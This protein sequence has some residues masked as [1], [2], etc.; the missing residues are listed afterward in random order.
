M[1][2]MDRIIQRMIVTSER[3][4]RR[5]ALLSELA[6]TRAAVHKASLRLSATETALG[7]CGSE[8]Q[9]EAMRSAIRRAEVE[10]QR[11]RMVVL[12]IMEVL[13]RLEARIERTQSRANIEVAGK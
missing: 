1:A 6:D 8:A 7:V 10:A 5:V 3:L 13:A 12:A 2:T 4:R 9:R 11:A